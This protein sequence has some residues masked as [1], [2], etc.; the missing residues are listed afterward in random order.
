MADSTLPVFFYDK[1][2]LIKNFIKEIMMR[3]TPTKQAFLVFSM[4]I[5][6]AGSNAYYP[7][8]AQSV[9]RDDTG[10][11]QTQGT[12]F[13]HQTPDT[14]TITIAVETEASSVSQAIDT[15]NRK[16][17]D[18]IAALRRLINP[19]T[20]SVRTTSFR[21]EPQHTYPERKAPVVTG[22]RVHNAVTV[23]T[24]QISRIGNMIDVA[25]QQGANYVQNINFFIEDEQVHCRNVLT[26]ATRAA[27]TKADILAGA[28][29]LRITG[30]KNVQGTCGAT[31][32]YPPPRPFAE[33]RATAP[34]D[35]VS[36]P[37]ETGDVRIN[38]SV[39][40]QFQAE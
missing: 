34:A 19:A 11:I 38:G 4:A 18:V 7:A 16:A 32:D 14:A 1:M 17:N 9:Q 2:V 21:V 29:G 27:Q 12:A 37:I 31:G 5:M 23:R 39:D 30:V 6:I 35:T 15:N 24:K 36:V 8:N 13:E 10:V 3:L 33:M 40:I 25:V 20:D 26:Q 28:L 22:Y